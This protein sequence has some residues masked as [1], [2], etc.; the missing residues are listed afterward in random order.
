MENTEN[1][2][3]R[4][5][6]I[7]TML[8]SKRVEGWV[9]GGWVVGNGAGLVKGHRLAVLSKFGRCNVQPGDSS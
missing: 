1:N 9:P 4:I 7:K 8:V 6:C 2:S 3:M 5:L